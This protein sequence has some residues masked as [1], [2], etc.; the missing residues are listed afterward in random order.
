MNCSKH[1]FWKVANTDFS[2][3]FATNVKSLTQEL[4]GSNYIFDICIKIKLRPVL[5]QIQQRCKCP[6]QEKLVFGSI[7]INQSFPCNHFFS[8][9]YFFP[10]NV[11]TIPTS[12]LLFLIHYLVLCSQIILSTA[13]FYLLPA[14]AYSHFW[15]STHLPTDYVS[16]RY[17]TGTF[18]EL[19]RRSNALPLEVWV[20][21]QCFT[22]WSSAFRAKQMTE[23][24]RHAE[25]LHY[26]FETITK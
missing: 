6:S 10:G 20:E 7:I 16:S 21:A 13:Y 26:T 4:P 22:R 3:N 24:H 14:L 23:P 1:W 8:L 5:L 25:I 12:V 18:H 2:Y 9:Q 11:F 17:F 15:L 19:H